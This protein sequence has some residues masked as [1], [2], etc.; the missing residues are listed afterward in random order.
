MTDKLGTLNRD[1]DKITGEIEKINSRWEG[2]RMG[3]TDDGR[4]DAKKRDELAHEAMAIQNEIE[5]ETKASQVLA[6][7]RQLREIPDP[8][9]PNSGS[10][11]KGDS[12]NDREIGGYVTLG[13]MVIASQEF[14]EFAKTSYARGHVAVIQLSHAAM[15]GKN[16]HQGQHGEPLIPLTRTQRKMFDEFLRSPQSKAV[17]TLGTGVIEPER[18]GRLAQV[19]ADQRINLRDVMSTGRTTSNAVEYVREEG[20][21]GSAGVQTPGQPKAELAVEY[22]LQSAPVRTIAGWMPVQNQQLEDWAQLRG[23]IDGRLRY[24]VQLKEEQSIMYGTGIGLELEGILNVNGIQDIASN[25]RYN[26]ST[27]TL[28]DAVRMGI[29]DIFV[30]GYQANAVMC[31]PRDWE[32]IL[33]EKGSD[34]RYVWAVVTTDNGSRLWG[35]RVVE[36]VGMESTV[37]GEVGRREVLVADTN[38]GAQIIDR[39]D[40]TVQ[41]GLV[42]DQLIRNMRTILAEER[43]ALPIYAPKA[44]AHFTTEAG[45][46]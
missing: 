19:T 29:T 3:E 15:H 24:K 14:Q 28:I 26:G 1:L 43:I 8:T 39:M 46:S 32:T 37:A 22:S 4:A 20:I 5:S 25:G 2:K 41:V 21:T 27:H 7:G 13:D 33:L 10:H 17:P 12:P 45:G 9:L 30:A 31:D 35:L 23:L 18:L 44:F 34:D 36:S 40:L 16:I 11:A 6:R 42:D 38:M